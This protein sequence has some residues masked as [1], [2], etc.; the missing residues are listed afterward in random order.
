MTSFDVKVLR[1]RSTVGRFKPVTRRDCLPPFFPLRSYKEV[2][3]ETEL[4]VGVETDIK[5]Q[6]RS[7]MTCQE[8]RHQDPRLPV[9]GGTKTEEGTRD[10]G[11]S[12]Y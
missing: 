2:E 9:V 4:T 10:V 1:E 8:R 11:P 7:R 5:E 12:L 6:P 3:N